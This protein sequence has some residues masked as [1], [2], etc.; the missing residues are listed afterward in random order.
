MQLDVENQL[1]RVTEAITEIDNRINEVFGYRAN[2]IIAIPYKI[3]WKEE[4]IDIVYKII[5]LRKKKDST[6]CFK[7]LELSYT[8]IMTDYIR[9]YIR[10]PILHN[11]NYDAY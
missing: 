7:D 10:N 3:N 8:E 5:G 2:N 6:E 4:S 9:D 1:E 11:S